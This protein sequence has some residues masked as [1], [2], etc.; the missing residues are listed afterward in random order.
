MVVSKMHKIEKLQFGENW[1]NAIWKKWTKLQFAK[2]WKQLQK[3]WK[4]IQKK[5]HVDIIWPATGQII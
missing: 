1:K 2:N 5:M 4:Q 3:K